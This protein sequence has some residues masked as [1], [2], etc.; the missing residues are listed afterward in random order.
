MA[1]VAI[2]A[3]IAALAVATVV[4]VVDPAILDDS[5][6]FL[7]S[8]IAGDL[9]NVIGVVLAIFLP[10]AATL[11]L[12]LAELEI[13]LRAN[14]SDAKGQVVSSTIIVLLLFIGTVILLIFKGLTDGLGR[15]AAM[16][17]GVALVLLLAH[18][19]VLF[20]ITRAV[21]LAAD[22]E[23]DAQSVEQDR[24]NHPT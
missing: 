4:A 13:R 18:I 22:G 5:N 1:K 19:L 11:Y 10:S 14:L 16:Y 21:F 3:L 7:K 17:N 15:D 2:F 23:R 6:S 24:T 12:K 8:F 20:D 9:L